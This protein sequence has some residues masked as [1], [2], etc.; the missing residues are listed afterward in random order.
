MADEDVIRDGLEAE[1]LLA[2]PTFKKVLK[3]V[4]DG[5][6]TDWKAAT[7]VQ[8]REECH[9]ILKATDGIVV[10]LNRMSGARVAKEAEDKRYNRNPK[11]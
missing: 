9:A 2:D 10:E 3:R 5:A 1:R 4:E 11:R 6:F 8:K 7:T